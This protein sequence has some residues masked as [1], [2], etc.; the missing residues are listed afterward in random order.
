MVKRHNRHLLSAARNGHQD[1]ARLLLSDPRRDGDESA[2]LVKASYAGHICIV[3]LL[4][5][6]RR[7]KGSWEN[8]ACL[9]EACRQGHLAVAQLLLSITDADINAY[10][11]PTGWLNAG[12]V[13]SPFR[14]AQ[15]SG[16]TDVLEY[17]LK[18]PRLDM[19]S[20]ANKQ[21]NKGNK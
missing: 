1:V 11:I 13:S 17:L 3:D 9:R 5:K 16:H 15:H 10:E 19:D 2:A 21:G 14:E 18:D 20:I 4:L 8:S 7:F 12:T 6:D